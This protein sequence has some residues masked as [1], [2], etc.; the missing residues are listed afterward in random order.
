MSTLEA[1][2]KPRSIAV[3][4]ASRQPGKIGYEILR[5][6]KEYGYG[7]RIY[8]VNP[9]AK[10]IL[11]LKA[12]PSIS[13]IPDSV[14]MVVV[15][16]PAH[17]VPD[18]IEEAG[19]KG[20]K[21]AVVISSGFKEIGRHDLE[22]EIVLRARKYGMRIL[23]PNIFG[24]VYTPARIN[25][26][27][28][29][30]DVIPGHIA[31]I[32]QSGALGIAL[33][34]M[35]IVEKIGVSTIIS[36]GNKSDIDDADLLEYLVGD[37]ATK[38]ILIY[39]EGVK[40]GKRFIEVARKVSTSKPVIVI[41]AGKTEVGAKAVASHTGSLAGNVLIYSTVFKQTGILE[42]RS[43]EEA[44]DWA[45]TFS[46]SPEYRDGDLVVVTN[47][48]GAGVLVTDTLSMNGVQLSPPPE[49]LV[50]A[51][52]PKL[53]GFASLGNPIDV[54]GMISNEGYV[55]AVMSA[56]LD[57]KVGIVLA[58]YCQTAVTDPTIIAGE[59][60]KRIKELGGLP[61]PLIA[62]FIGGEEVYWAI[63]KLNNAGIPAFP[64][65]ERAASSVAAL[66]NYSRIR[67]RLLRNA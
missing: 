28:G 40:D 67:K 12:Y 25:A 5:N 32:T 4:G 17:M 60:I 38:V 33:M 31:F 48:G 55:D 59:L 44:F 30:K 24:V 23:G 51:L 42:A 54:T 65:P 43:V 39:L 41:K 16:V 57:D 52:K 9:Q 46:Y 35:T 27:F 19:R 2:F 10:E 47:G 8:P 15:S 13:S 22:E 58:V 56:L 21:V 36:I 50:N 45:R 26:S 18:V 1:L 63:Q 34:G 37:E 20:V 61:K 7:G 6:L 3:V 53:P 14:D 49:T 29:P 64:M 11:G 62:S 66:I